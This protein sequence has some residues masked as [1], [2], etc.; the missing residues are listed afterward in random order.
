MVQGRYGSSTCLHVGAAR[1]IQV[2]TMRE[3][4][5]KQWKPLM[6]WVCKIIREALEYIRSSISDGPS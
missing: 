3:H 2:T 6:F 1:V 5:E 4:L